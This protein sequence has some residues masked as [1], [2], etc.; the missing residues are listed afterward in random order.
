MP[1]RRRPIKAP[2]I[3]QTSPELEG[4]LR[5]HQK[6]GGEWFHLMD[7]R[8]LVFGSHFKGTGQRV[9]QT[10]DLSSVDPGS[11][12]PD[13]LVQATA[14]LSKTLCADPFVVATIFDPEELLEFHRVLAA[15]SRGALRAVELQK[16][17]R[18]SPRVEKY[19][20]SLILQILDEGIQAPFVSEA[21]AWAVQDILGR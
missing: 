9:M 1:S 20:E 10:G 11:P 15:L 13:K 5:D 7:L 16:R 6:P 18:T 8:G 3:N 4:F 19:I 2:E 12:T 17:Q 14:R 21:F